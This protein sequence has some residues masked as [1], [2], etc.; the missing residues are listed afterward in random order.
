MR[1]ILFFY[2]G[3]L[4]SIVSYSQTDVKG[5][6][7]NADSGEPIPGASIV[8]KG[9]RQG[10]ISGEDGRFSLKV[11]KGFDALEVSAVTFLTQE[12][13]VAPELDIRLKTSGST[14]LNEVMV[15]GYGTKIKRD[16]TSSISRVSAKDFEEQPVS[17]FEQAL[18]GRASGVFI[19]S[20]SGKLGQGLK[21]RVRGIS[22]ISA[23]QQPFVVIDGVPVVNQQL[24]SSDEPDNPLA[25][26][27]PDDIESI[28]VL[29]D[30]S[31]AAIYGA[32]ASNG[33]IL[34]TTKSGKQGKTKVN[35][36]ISNGW[37]TPTHYQQFLNA[38]QY[39]ELFTAAAENAGYNAADEFA[40][41]TGTDD[42][43]SNNNTNWA[44][45]AFQNGYV[46]QYTASVSGGDARTRFLA[47]ASYNDQKGIIIGN[48]L[49]RATGRINLEHDLNK[50]FKVGA[51]ISLNQTNNYRVS[52]DNAFSNPVQLNALPPIQPMYDPATGLLNRNTL[53]YNS[54][55]E[56]EG[57][58]RNWN[59]IYRTTSSAFIEANI[60]P[61]LK[62]RSQNGI[63][64]TNLQES[65]F[66]G[67]R[68]E[69]GAPGGYSYE[70][71]TTSSIFTT[72]NTLSW[73]KSFAK[74]DVDALAGIEYQNGKV[75]GENVT[76]R[77]F[78]S[79]KF[80]RI[81]SAAIIT[82]GSSTATQYRFM[83]Y[84]F[85]SN[86]KFD[87]KY[88]LSASVRADGSSRFS[89]NKP[90]GVFPA[91][92]AGWIISQ[93]NFLKE[94][95]ALSFL[96][97]RSSYG[98]TG[99]AE[100]GNFSSLTLFESSPYAN[101]A[102]II[103]S[104]VGD[105]NL[106]W[107]KTDQF[108]LGLDFGFLNN[109]I[110]GEVDYFFKKTKDLLLDIPLPSV[111]GFT[112]ITK[113]IGDMQNKGWEFVLNADV[114]RNA[115]FKW[116]TSFNISTYRNKVTRLVAPVQPTDRNVGRLAVGAPFGQFY[117]K[118]YMGVDP[119]NGDALY[120]KADGTTTN[121]Y[122]LAVDT[123]V[124]NPNPD[125]YGGWNNKIS[126]KGF[127]L[128]ILT[129]FVKGGDIFNLAGI[130]QSVNGDYFDN[131]TVDQMNYWKKPGDVT[132]V[133][134]PR[135]YEGN[136]T[137]KSSRWVQ[138]GSYFRLKSVTLS[139]SL[140]RQLAG[141]VKASN[142]KLFLSGQNLLTLTKYKGY[143]PEVNTQFIGS[144]NLNHDFYT[145]PLAKTFLIG[146][147]V[148]L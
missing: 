80:T 105:P 123:V 129:Q 134:Q 148:D 66:L 118:K 36:G 116:T 45:A 31:S 33:V 138:D 111:N 143:D 56:V 128:D 38:D 34:V 145:P 112:V 110:S 146:L 15:V 83:S 101:I 115:A 65:N 137:N 98:R 3:L 61:N 28:E 103:A 39:R 29:K 9:T 72:T 125:Y 144:V 51:N 55:I 27:N 16:V 79:D 140:P 20:G 5:T 92:S 130:F 42:W 50:I 95:K 32:R 68:T 11:P 114:I 102:G 1:K 2:L 13:T 64:W 44:K 87:E 94:S 106:S 139:Y 99:N 108:D 58:N 120:M 81:A 136:G 52:S 63:D 89:K 84:F 22:S 109:R 41:E 62:F 96:K 14:D 77:A 74:T 86:F 97:L 24:S 43:N 46:R 131:Q 25:T 23:G 10:V 69:D 19:N 142:I 8:V 135:L 18:Q 7:K 121:D 4:F 100:I 124:G 70:G 30:A 88:L 53:Y 78:P 85:R 107:E 133:P 76:G 75:S 147:N 67:R 93:E 48:R 6:V 113:N 21:I 59:K 122:G 127:D 119:D 40:S 17:S 47:S 54:L 117:T 126:Y 57:N 26:L 49:T 132:N 37:S 71:Q 12:V 35:I 60:L 104:Q 90:Y 141:K 73:L 91:V 82:G